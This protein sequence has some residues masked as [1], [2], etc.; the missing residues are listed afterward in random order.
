MD[1]LWTDWVKEKQQIALRLSS[2]ECGGS[3]GEAVIILCAAL[4]TIAAKVWPGNGIDR[5]RFVQLLIE[6]APPNFDVAKISVPLLVGSLRSA[7]KIDE[8]GRIKTV[9]INYDPSRVLTGDEVDKTEQEILAVCSTL[10]SQELRECSYANLLYR[11]VRSSY[12]HEYRPG[13]RADPWP[14]TMD[15]NARVSYVNWA[16]DPDR[17]IHFHID[18]IAELAMSIAKAVDSVANKLPLQAPSK[19]WIEG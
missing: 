1:T 15:P 3:Y 8:M 10:N 18:W 6:Y 11:E 5:K 2:G 4:S 16:N 12:A 14:M 17:H 19:W 9:F 7:G 13:E